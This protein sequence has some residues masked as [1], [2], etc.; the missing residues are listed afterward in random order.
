MFM[1]VGILL[2]VH[3]GVGDGWLPLVKAQLCCQLTMNQR[4]MVLVLVTDV[5][6]TDVNLAL[7]CDSRGRLER[8]GQW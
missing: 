4:G 3:A 8:G 1:A 2:A 6:A 5:L 7:S